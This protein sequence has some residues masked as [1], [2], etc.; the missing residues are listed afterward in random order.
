MKVC[1]WV[2]L[3]LLSLL[4]YLERQVLAMSFPFSARMPLRPVPKRRP[5]KQFIII[6]CSCRNVFHF[7]S[8]AYSSLPAEIS[9]TKEVVVI[10]SGHRSIFSRN[11]R[12]IGLPLQPIET[13][14]G[15]IFLNH[16]PPICNDNWF[17]NQSPILQLVQRQEVFCLQTVVHNC[18]L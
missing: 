8:L 18:N 5:W 7:W 14:C 4:Y 3:N 10:A 6:P 11:A 15:P 16:L 2:H 17:C 9:C 1:F 13:F 12:N